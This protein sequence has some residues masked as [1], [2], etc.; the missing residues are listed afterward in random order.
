MKRSR[1]CSSPATAARARPEMSIGDAWRTE[2]TIHKVYIFENLTILK[3]SW[4][5]MGNFFF[6]AWIIR[7][8]IRISNKIV[9]KFKMEVK[10]DFSCTERFLKQNIFSDSLIPH[11][12]TIR[13]CICMLP[14]VTSLLFDPIRTEI[15]IKSSTNWTTTY[16]CKRN[17]C[18]AKDES[19]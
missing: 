11:Q 2:K 5:K 9:V 13:G 17:C 4:A 16:M 12:G 15:L 3:F 8:H 19:S 1:A 10:C 6:V 14:N 7:K 18:R